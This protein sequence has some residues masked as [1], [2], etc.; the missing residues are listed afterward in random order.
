MCTVHMFYHFDKQ[1]NQDYIMC[2]DYLMIRNIP[3]IFHRKGSKYYKF[4]LC[5]QGFSQKSIF[6]GMSISKSHLLRNM[7]EYHCMTG[8]A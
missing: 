3:G 5:T 4:C 1:L 8:K 6:V 2:T 7:N